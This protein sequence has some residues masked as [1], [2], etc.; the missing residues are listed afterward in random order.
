[1]SQASLFDAEDQ[2]AERV[3][4]FLLTLLRGANRP[5]AD[6]LLQM[7]E[8]EL[9]HSARWHLT[10]AVRALS[11]QPDPPPPPWPHPPEYGAEN[12]IFTTEMAQSARLR[13]LVRIAKQNREYLTTM[14]EDGSLAAALQV[15]E[16]KVAQQVVAFL[17]TLL[18][19]PTRPS[20]QELLQAVEYQIGLSA[21]WYLTEAMKTISNEKG[22]DAASRADRDYL[23]A[24]LE[25]GSI[26]AALRGGDGVDPEI[27]S[28]VDALVRQSALLRSTT[29][30]RATINF[31]AKFRR[32]SPYNN[33]LVRVQNPSCSFFA[34]QADWAGRF[35]R[36]LKEDA[37]PLLILAPMHPV[38]LVYE[39]DATAGDPLPDLLEEFA[40]FKGD[41]ESDWLASLVEN[42]SRYKIQ[43]A[44]KTLSSTHGGFATRHRAT[45]T[46]KMRIVV[47]DDLDEPSRY[48]VLCHELA[49]V[50]L[51]HLGS[52]TDRWWPARSSLDHTTV[53][54]E[55]ESVA[56][57][58]TTRLGLSGMSA[59]YVAM[60]RHDGAV[61]LSVSMDT[62]AKV[63]GLLERM[64]KTKV[65]APKPRPPRPRRL[66]RSAT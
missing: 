3:R 19:G 46:W 50:L 13:L 43:V 29:A 30:Y 61:P 53:E 40:Q 59:G 54:I 44:F 42:A 58:V 34:T 7:L 28:T 35:N 33:M 27:V 24:M 36:S 52:D 1:M 6:D 47:H 64:T 32:Y 39:L 2:L 65:P 45:G 66:V 12:K 55:A 56:Y 48:G 26:A 49:H 51:G 8:R 38:M 10:D 18:Q 15:A 5:S 25:D 23:A 9:G 20:A 16:D 31:M 22:P 62:V 17:R 63:A 11:T 37:R 4:E 21:R 41:W 57:I 60:L 14:L